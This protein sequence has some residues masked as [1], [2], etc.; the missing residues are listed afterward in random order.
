MPFTDEQEAFI[1]VIGTGESCAAEA[2][3]GSGKTTTLVAALA[4]VPHSSGIFLVFNKA[5]ATALQSKITRPGYEA[6]TLNALGHGIWS[7]KL[8]KRLTLNSRKTGDN[9]TTFVNEQKLKLGDGD[10]IDLCKTISLAKAFAITPGTMN[11]PAPDFVLLRNAMDERGIEPELLDTYEGLVLEQLKLSYKQAWQ[12]LIDFDDQL[13]CPV[14]SKTVFPTI[15]FVGVDEA[16]DLSTLQH[17]MIARLRAEQ[18]AVIG[19]PHQAIYAFRG[20]SSESFSELIE[21][22]SLRTL[23]LTYSFRC[24]QAVAEYARAFVPHFRAYP[25]NVQGTVNHTHGVFLKPSTT[26][27]ARYNAPLVKL[28]FEGIRTGVAVNY[29]GRDFLAGLKTLHKKHPTRDDL[30]AWFRAKLAKAKTKGA[31]QRIEDQYNSLMILHGSNSSVEAALTSMM[32]DSTSGRA[33][34]LSTVHKAKGL[35]W[36]EVTYL[37]SSLDADLGQESNMSYVAVTRTQ[38]TLNLH[39]SEK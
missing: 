17:E 13:Y 36:N 34:T 16:Q 12:G 20:A 25:T 10:F 18:R 11:T 29:L 21:K 22:F 39:T 8:G 27:I 26:I 23:P 3:A 31:V 4:A 33:V 19:D 24:P 30:G 38:D 14:V 28:A 5:N 35:E 7:K 15:P 32:I 37:N 9:L 6:K 2:V 1:S